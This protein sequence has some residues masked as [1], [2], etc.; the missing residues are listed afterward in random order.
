MHQPGL[1]YQEYFFRSCSLFAVDAP[2]HSHW[3]EGSVFVLL[4]LVLIVVSKSTVSYLF[5]LNHD[6]KIKTHKADYIVPLCFE[7]RIKGSF[8]Y[9]TKQI[10][11]HIMQT[12]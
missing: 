8:G 3:S 4:V 1:Q 5:I 2:V 10:E 7:L 6:Q 12:E 9:K 11:A